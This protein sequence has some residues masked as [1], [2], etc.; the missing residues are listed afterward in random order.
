MSAKKIR[1]SMSRLTG[2]ARHRT[3]TPEL[4]D[5]DA[6]RREFGIARRPR[7]QRRRLTDQIIEQEE[8]R[9]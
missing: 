6:L 8:R 2:E 7:G 9:G 4:A 1:V 3:Q 5:K